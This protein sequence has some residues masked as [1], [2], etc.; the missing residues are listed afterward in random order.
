MIKNNYISHELF[1]IYIAFSNIVFSLYYNII[2]IFS[3]MNISLNQ[4]YLEIKKIF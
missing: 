4:G 3:K 2:H 1:N